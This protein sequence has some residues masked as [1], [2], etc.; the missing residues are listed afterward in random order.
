MKHYFFSIISLLVLLFSSCTNKDDL[1]GGSILEINQ[2]TVD[3]SSEAGVEEIEIKTNSVNWTATVA[4]D[5]K[6]WCSAY[7]E[8]SGD[9]SKLRIEVTANL[10]RSQRS[11]TVTVATDG[12][13]KQI[14]V[15]QLGIDKGI[16]I[17]PLMLTTESVGGNF[18]LKVTANVEYDITVMDE[19]VS[20]TPKSRAE[21]KDDNYTL[22]VQRNTGDER[23]TQVFVKDK[24]SELSAELLVIQKKMGDYQGE[25]SRLGDDLLVP[26]S[27]GKALNAKG[28]NS[29]LG[30]SGF[31]RAYD[32]SRDTGYHSGDKRTEKPDAW[33]LSLTFEF[34]DQPVV[35]Y[36]VYY[37]NGNKIT[38]GKIYVTTKDKEEYELM[39]IDLPESGT[40]RIDFPKRIENPVSIRFEVTESSGEYVI[41]K[42]IEFYRSNPENFD[43]STLFE[44]VACT[45]LKAGITQE[46]IE[47]CQY[48]LFREM[49]IYMLLD[50]Y[51][52][53]F[54]I[55]EYKAY[56]HPDKFKR[57]NR[58]SAPHNLFD[59]PTGI[60]VKKG[61]E[62]VILVDNP[63]R[64]SL[65]VRVLNLNTPGNDGFNYNYS[66]PVAHGINKFIA[67]TDGLIYICYYSD[68]YDNVSPIT[69]HIPTGEVNGYY[70]IQK[71]TQ[72]DWMRLLDKAVAPHF[73]LLGKNSHL[74]YST[75]DFR[76]YVIDGKALVEKYDL[77]VQLERDF[78]GFTKYAQNNSLRKEVNRVCFSVMYNDSYMY[79]AAYHT[80]YVNTTMKELCDINK[81]VTSSIWGPAH[82][83]GHSYQ[84][85]P[86]LKWHGMTEVTNNILSLYVQTSFANRA[87][88]W[89]KQGDYTSIYEKSMNC[90]FVLNEG[91][92]PHNRTDLSDGANVFNQLVPFW[93]LYLY[94]KAIGKDDFYKD[95]YELMRTAP[96]IPSEEP[97]KSQVNFAVRASKI[98]ELDLTD[99]FEKWGF[100][101]PVDYLRDDYREKQFTVTEEMAADAKNEI[102]SLGYPE[103]GCC[104]EYITEDNAN[105][106]V[107]KP[108]IVGGTVQR[109]GNNFV[110]SNCQN[111]VA[112][113]VYSD[114]K[115]CFVSPVS[116]FNV[117]GTLG[118][119]IEVYAIPASGEN[120]KVKLNIN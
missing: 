30:T 108:A 26:V 72:E 56:P 98:A 71:H 110:I 43:T 64:V 8:I 111:A 9:V 66:Y 116:T 34:K 21:Y 28:E 88:L 109:D 23:S 33:P 82:E 87:R 62:V 68:D 36:C 76:T 74:M 83:V 93:Q 29:Q 77:L 58:T 81:F 20:V 92:R 97:G 7:P 100:F 51:P 104:I 12:L 112:Y 57:E 73:D 107:T 103:P 1:G 63:D 115:L 60:F 54:R 120:N 35:D 84:H 39:D 45:K 94:T 16:L 25:E 91:K 24:D 52:R 22:K 105:L 10:E 27:G 55:D 2:S 96:E 80:G 4:S 5:G 85:I 13:T 40:S 49:A 89:D 32:G 41:I 101:I 90:F 14:T 75:E 102:K 46:E 114:G 67:E 18:D 37:T 44:D 19:W 95:L 86:G 61:Q 99:F 59:N 31:S 118:N 113:Q 79:S 65:S 117:V 38:K 11:T 17:S 53:E 47:K 70:N 6:S 15:R 78:M 69:V 48:P 50:K 119:D 106:Y 3:F 42:E